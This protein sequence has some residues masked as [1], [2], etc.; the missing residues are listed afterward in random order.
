VPRKSAASL[1]VVTPI[2]DHRLP[3]PEGMSAPEALI[4]RRLM[5]RVPNGWFRAEHIE[6]L[7]A[8]C[9]HGAIADTIARSIREF[10]PEWL[11]QDGGLERL[12]GLTKLLDREHRLVLALARS[13]RLT[14]QAFDPK[15]AASHLNAQ[16]RWGYIGGN[17]G[18]VE[19][20]LPWESHK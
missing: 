6:L 20:K 14:H 13:M 12:D 7:A 2:Q 16:P 1:S 10:R 15:V 5:D 8:Y 9:E 3:A 11:G 4:W 19:R 18:L 17:G